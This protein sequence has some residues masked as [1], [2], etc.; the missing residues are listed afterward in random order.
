MQ[1]KEVAKL[2]KSIVPVVQ[3]AASLKITDAATMEAAAAQLTA[4]NRA[5]DEVKAAKE[6]ITKPMNAALKEARAL[7]APIEDKLEAAIGSVR[8]EMT[9]YQTEAEAEKSR[10]AARV[11]EGRGKLKVETAVGKIA[12]IGAPEKVAAA[13]GGAVQFV[14]TPCFEI[15]DASALPRE[16][17]I[18]DEVAIRKALIGGAVIPGTKFWI[19]K[20]PKNTR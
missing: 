7:F 17:L 19:E 9:R 12:A 10:I 8:K 6:A 14:D 4:L 16:Y 5:A 3:K 2:E 13:N 11:G 15:V 1:T 20:R 18:P